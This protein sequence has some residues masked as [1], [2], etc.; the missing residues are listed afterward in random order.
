MTRKPSTPCFYTINDVA[1]I[2]QASPRT[3]RRCIDRGDLKSHKLKSL[4]RIS[5]DD[6]KAFLALRRRV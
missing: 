1:G 4:I 6:L 5:E 2:L 3:V